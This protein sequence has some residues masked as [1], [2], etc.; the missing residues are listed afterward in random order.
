[1]DLLTK[2]GR[3]VPIEFLARQLGRRPGGLMDDLTRLEERGAV[4]IDRHNQ[5]VKLR[6]RE[7]KK[8]GFGRLLETIFGAK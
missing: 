6:Q 1:V 3:E 5:T 8:S 2:F 7:G 4:K